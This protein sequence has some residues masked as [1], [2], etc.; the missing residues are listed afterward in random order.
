MTPLRSF[1]PAYPCSPANRCRQCAWCKRVAERQ[2]I[3]KPLDKPAALAALM[4]GQTITA[5]ARAHGLSRRHVTRLLAVEL[6]AHPQLSARGRRARPLD[7]RLADR[8]TARGLTVDQ[9]AANLGVATSTLTL[10][11]RAARQHAWSSQ[12]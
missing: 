5:L 10:R 8:L 7:L 6:A 3:C 1:D 11:R 12:P 4:G 9:V 2:R